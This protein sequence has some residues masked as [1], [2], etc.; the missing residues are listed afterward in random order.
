MINGK[1]FILQ[2]ELLTADIWFSET[3]FALT[4]EW[5]NVCSIKAKPN[6]YQK[7]PTPIPKHSEKETV[8]V[9]QSNDRKSPELNGISEEK[10]KSSSESLKEFG[11][12]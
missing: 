8:E 11:M 9:F 10:C 5:G 7:K 1:S 3:F 4:N 2:F 12:E 6:Q